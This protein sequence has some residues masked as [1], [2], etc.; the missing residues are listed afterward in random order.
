MAYA[1]IADIHGNM[2]A[3]KAVIKDAQM[4]GVKHFAF[5]GDYC[6]GLAYPNEVL[7]LIRSLDS[8]YVV[9][10][11]E[12][13]SFIHWE[14]IPPCSWPD[15]QYEAGPWYYKN[16]TSI[17]RNFICDLPNEIIVESDNMPPVHLFHKPERYF[18]EST[19]SK[20]APH[21][22]ANGMDC[23]KFTIQSFSSY[24]KDL[25]KND[26][27]LHKQLLMLNNGVY[28]FGHKHIQWFQ[29]QSGK[30]LICPGSCGV[31]LDFQTTAAYAILEWKKSY[32]EC[33]L[34]RVFYDVSTAIS[35]MDETACA[36]EIPVWYGIISKE[37][38]T[39]R[40]QAIPFLHYAEQYANSIGD[41]TRPF[42]RKTWYASY[43]AWLNT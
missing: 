13:E 15:G 30:L 12:D 34:R 31:P 33:E 1:L 7:D 18:P 3:L 17:N 32:W 16:L 25:Q 24:C 27:L 11:N 5:L 22:Y 41:P 29:E 10:G 19:P 4:M 9:S 21:F 36:K 2:P 6:V 26:S 28:V 37:T 14:T 43:N 23:N 38:K 35:V 39:G 40:A 8:T 20:I 42:T